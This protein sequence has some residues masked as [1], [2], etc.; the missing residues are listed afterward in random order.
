MF[1]IIYEVPKKKA[2]AAQRFKRDRLIDDALHGKLADEIK[3]LQEKREQ[4]LVSNGVSLPPY[5]QPDGMMTPDR[6]SLIDNLVLEY[7]KNPD[8]KEKLLTKAEIETQVLSSLAPEP[9]VDYDYSIKDDGFI[10]ASK[11]FLK[12]FFVG[13]AADVYGNP[14]EY[15]LSSQVMNAVSMLATT[16]P[17]YRMAIVTADIAVLATS[18]YSR[19]RKVKQLADTLTPEGRRL[20]GLEDINVSTEVGKDVV[21]QLAGGFVF[22]RGIRGLSKATKFTYNKAINSFPFK[23]RNLQKTVPLQSN[24]T[25]AKNYRSSEINSALANIAN[26]ATPLEKVRFVEALNNEN[27]CSVLSKEQIMKVDSDTVRY[28]KALLEGDSIEMKNILSEPSIPVVS[29]ET[30]HIST[31]S[32]SGLVGFD[33]SKITLDEIKETA[34]AHSRATNE[35]RNSRILA[36]DINLSGDKAVDFKNLLEEHLKIRFESMYDIS[37][38][39][40]IILGGLKKSIV[41]LLENNVSPKLNGFS[42]SDMNGFKTKAQKESAF[43]FN[44]KL[45]RAE[46]TESILRGVKYRRNLTT[47][48]MDAVLGTHLER[49]SSHVDSTLMPQ[50]KNL[51]ES[52]REATRSQPTKIDVADFFDVVHG[53]SNSTRMLGVKNA[54]DSMVDAIGEL[55]VESGVDLTV[56]ETYFP[57]KWSHSKIVVPKELEAYRKAEF[58]SD[59]LGAVDI[60]AMQKL[61]N[62]EVNETFFEKMY[63]GIKNQ[64]SS[65]S[66]RVIVMKDGASWKAMHEKYGDLKTVEDVMISFYSGAKEKISSSLLG[67]KDTSYVSAQTNAIEQIIINNSKNDKLSFRETIRNDANKWNGIIT[68]VDIIGNRIPDWIQDTMSAIISTKAGSAFS[69]AFLTDRFGTMQT[70]ASGI[71][72][73]SPIIDSFKFFGESSKKELNDLFNINYNSARD[74]RRIAHQ[75]VRVKNALNIGIDAGKSILTIPG[76]LNSFV[77]SQNESAS[78]YAFGATLGRNLEKKF[79]K[80][81]SKTKRYFSESGITE[82]IWDFL[83]GIEPKYILGDEGSFFKTEPTPMVTSKLIDSYIVGKKIDSANIPLARTARDILANMETGYSLMASPRSTIAGR[84]TMPKSTSALVN[85]KSQ[86][87]HPFINIAYSVWVH[88]IREQVDR[89]GAFPVISRLIV[90]GLVAA[91]INSILKKGKPLDFTDP[92]DL[93]R[94]FAFIGMLGTAEVLV[95][96]LF[97]PQYGDLGNIYSSAKSISEGNIYK[98]ATSA[99]RLFNPFANFGLIGKSLTSYGIDSWFS[100]FDPKGAEEYD[101]QLK[102]KLRRGEISE[103]LYLALRPKNLKKVFK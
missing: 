13:I 101:K 38:E 45:R 58:A 23:S 73:K 17:Y 37:N 59:M 36:N 89:F 62:K 65:K 99:L 87:T 11:E 2:T 16:S 69:T 79:G 39:E 15:G 8:N 6:D 22:S 24:K 61:T 57:N 66:N 51:G 55:G 33:I 68:N 18:S 81:S 1:D 49:V 32:G 64:D 12:D 93:S 43:N 47:N 75:S 78:N 84:K 63:D 19:R 20:L 3:T 52:L 25:V 80:L 35:V 30:K 92:K 70:A 42:L 88:G 46:L 9:N 44:A 76:T 90:G 53:K 85:I 41:D 40:G 54:W 98:G 71:G 50:L 94:A 96:D 10:G 31:K 97:G 60:P 77:T 14:L 74:A 102:R 7:N 56:K 72:A 34:K 27:P 91:E 100:L 95:E 103:F 21:T 83:R 5:I 28:A 82:E 4:K 29:K 48:T 86:L 67:S 26:E